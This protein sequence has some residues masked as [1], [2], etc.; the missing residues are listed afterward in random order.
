MA[1]FRTITNSVATVLRNISLTYVHYV[2]IDYFS[3]SL[4]GI[5]RWLTTVTAKANRSRQKKIQSRQKQI[6]SMLYF[7][8]AEYTTLVSSVYILLAI[9]QFAEEFLASAHLCYVRY[10][11]TE[12]IR[13]PVS[14]I[15]IRNLEM[16]SPRSGVRVHFYI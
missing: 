13:K 3:V 2:S 7:Y 11:S 10:T 12:T 6:N 16:K 15:F 9:L 5:L 4:V 8:P 14:T 1:A